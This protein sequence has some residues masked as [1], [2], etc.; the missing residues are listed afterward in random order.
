MSPLRCPWSTRSL[1][2]PNLTKRSPRSSLVL[3]YRSPQ[4]RGQYKLPGASPQSWWLL[5]DTYP[6]RERIPRVTTHTKSCW[7]R[8]WSALA[9]ITQKIAEIHT[10]KLWLGVQIFGGSWKSSRIVFQCLEWMLGVANRDRRGW[11]P[12][13]SSCSKTSCWG[14]RLLD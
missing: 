11:G 1:S 3:H 5:D 8:W 4:R 2:T 12:F 6:S 9:W 10:Q 13:Y 7:W 14:V